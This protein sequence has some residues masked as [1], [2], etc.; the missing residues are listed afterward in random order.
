MLNYHLIHSQPAET[1]VAHFEHYL[2]LGSHQ[3]PYQVAPLKSFSAVTLHPEIR[4]VADDLK[5][6]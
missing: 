6:P 1:K 5:Q 2:T 3:A 4:M